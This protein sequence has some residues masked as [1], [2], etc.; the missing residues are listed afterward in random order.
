MTDLSSTTPTV[1]FG[2]LPRRGFLLGLS[3][4]RVACLCVA[5]AVFVPSI[6]VGGAI[7]A[8]VTSPLWGGCGALAFVRWN[9]RPLVE[10]LPTAGHF[11]LRHVEGQTRFRARPAAPRPSG[12]LA[13]PGD[14]A[15]IR[16][17]IDGESGT[18]MLHDPHAHTLSAVAVVHHPAYVLLAP[19]EQER[20]V[21]GWGRALASLAASGTGTRVQ[22]LEVSLPDAGRGITGWWD[23]HGEKKRR[24][25]WPIRQ[26]EMLMRCAA[27]S[28]STHRTLIAISLDLKAAR[29]HIRQSG[30]GL[31]GGVAFLRQEMT[32]LETGLRSADLTLAT[33]LNESEIAATLRET[34]EP[35]RDTD[36]TQSLADAGPVAMDEHWGYVRHDTAFSAVLWISE[37]PRVAVPPYFLHSLVFQAGIRKTL[38]L[39]IQPVPAD[40]AIRDIRKAKVEYATEAAQKAKIGAIADLSDSAERD[41]V[42]DRERALI[43]GH[44][45]V[46]FTGLVSIT[47]PTREALEG[48]VAEI[49]RA[50]I[51]CGCE[52]RRLYGQQARAFVS[53][54]LPLARK[55][56]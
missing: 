10:S 7:G 39:T 47:A 20:R 45:D 33:W 16:F 43:S 48:S 15:A 54:A 4:A 36:A 29:T 1:R 32:S 55:V 22:V 52:T 23:L 41:D 12:T 19:D 49:S 9:G 34:F 37:W 31:R 27:P 21:H 3:A 17:L 2:R 51:Q 50:A 40:V 6:F 53:A 11:L 5:I 38:S 46:K 26:Y 25:E 14:A 28:A 44:A 8:A 13:L 35:G 56:N 42:L 30:R 18:A 24:G